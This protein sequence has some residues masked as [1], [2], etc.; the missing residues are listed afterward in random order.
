M[1]TYSSTT[2]R[3]LTLSIDTEFSRVVI[4]GQLVAIARSDD[5]FFGVLHARP[6]EL[7]AL[8]LGTSLEDRP[9]YT[10]TTAFETYP[11]PWP[12]GTE[13][14]DDPRVQAISA[15]AKA[16]VE[17][18]DAWLNPPGLSEAELKK[19]TLTSLYNQRPPELAALHASLDAAVF[20]AYG[21]PEE[22]TDEEIL[23]R[24]LALNLQRAGSAATAVPS[25]EQ[26]SED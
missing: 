17:W 15:A 22:L 7:W 23:E 9:R 18:R 1:S 6:H 26:E 19:R 2:R 14:T 5:Y 24:L 16:L 25:Q 4:D 8:R 21:W 11:F 20:A 13:P 3:N 12:P 10:P